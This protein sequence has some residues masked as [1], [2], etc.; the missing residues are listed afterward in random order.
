MNLAKSSVKLAVASG[1]SAAITFG[2][3]ALFARL[4]PPAE[5]GVFFLFEALLGMLFIPADFGIRGALQKRISEGSNPGQM[6]TTAVLL[7]AVPLSIVVTAILVARPWINGYVGETIAV[8]LAVAIVGYELF[9]LGIDVLS[10]ELRVGETAGIRLAQKIVWLVAGYVLVEQGYG[11]RGLIFGLIAGYAVS[12]L[13]GMYRRSTPFLRPTFGEAH[14]LVSY[15]RYN[16]VSAISGYFYSWMDVALIGLF[17]TTSHVSTYEAAWRVSAVAVLGSTAI[18][19]TIFPQVSRWDADQARDR[20][21]RLIPRT[22]LPSLI[23]VVPAFFGTLL[24]SREIL[25]LV[26]GSEYT[27]AWLVLIILMGEKIFQAVHNITGRSLQAIDY[28]NLAARAAIIAIAINLAL[29]VPLIQL[30]G[31][32]GAAVATGI[33]F[34]VNA[35][36]CVRYLSRFIDVTIPWTDLGWVLASSLGMTLVLLVVQSTVRVDSL[37]RLAFVICV[38]V[39]AY[40]GFVLASPPLR[41]QIQRSARLLRSDQPRTDPTNGDD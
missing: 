38:G 30:Y 37:V 34:V 26:F 6:L 29:N 22:V 7:K 19:Q 9:Q 28:P 18:A 14:S 1:G 10:G 24:F 13:W 27:V 15:S 40:A 3:V 8:W 25:G 20:I 35:L 2:G 33:S 32:A 12:F 17:L 39:V 4:L 36:L 16:F 11:V 23:L 5:L 31:I 21:E 41:E